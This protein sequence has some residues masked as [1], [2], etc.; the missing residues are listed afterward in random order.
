MQ[1]VGGGEVAERGWRGKSRGAGGGR[2][3]LIRMAQSLEGLP[4][5]RAEQR[6]H[7]HVK[8]KSSD[9]MPIIQ[10]ERAM[11]RPRSSGNKNGMW[12]RRIASHDRVGRVSF[13]RSEPGC[14]NVDLP[15]PFSE[16]TKV[17]V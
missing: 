14:L 1:Q 10:V 7:E 9:A 11:Y 6:R 16:S 3:H 4:R 12:E 17:I 8:G 5:R 13:P 15:V 2:A